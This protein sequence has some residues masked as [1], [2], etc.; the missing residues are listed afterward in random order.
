MTSRYLFNLIATF[1]PVVGAKKLSH[2]NL[3][4]KEQRMDDIK[5]RLMQASSLDNSKLG[6]LLILG[7]DP[8]EHMLQETFQHFR[9]FET[10]NN[11]IKRFNLDIFG[12]KLT[13]VSKLSS[14]FVNTINSSNYQHLKA[15]TENHK[16]QNG[17]QASCLT[18]NLNIV[19]LPCRI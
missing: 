7:S 13:L 17:T 8:A 16:F 14:N 10:S 15:A 5:L 1:C 9:D 18:P 3:Q 12:S 2:K 4:E 11:W 6:A 19:F